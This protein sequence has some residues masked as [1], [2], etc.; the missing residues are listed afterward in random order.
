MRRL[1]EAAA[2]R[3]LAGHRRR[4]YWNVAALEQPTPL[5]ADT[6]IADEP[7]VLKPAPAGDEVRTDYQTLGYTLGTHPLTLLRSR[8]RARGVRR[9]REVSEQGHGTPVRAVG[10]VNL[11]QRPSTASGTVFLT[12]EDESGWLNVIVWPALAERQ[13]RT[14]LESSLLAV[15]GTFESAE[16]VS[17][18]IAR[19]LHDWSALLGGLDSRSRDFH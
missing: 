7:V 8:L 4:A 11:R 9:V 12:L 3:R 2:L 10:L 13:R 19:R 16:G 6:R 15:D 5:L 14:L 17:H 18:L 1:A